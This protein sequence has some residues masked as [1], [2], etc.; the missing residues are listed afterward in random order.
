MDDTYEELNFMLDGIHVNL[1]PSFVA[2]TTVFMVAARSEYIIWVS[3]E[4]LARVNRGLKLIKISESLTSSHPQ[5]LTLSQKALLDVTLA[6]SAIHKFRFTT[7]T[8]SCFFLYF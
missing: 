2:M 7:S 1:L 4:D 6:S 5:S 3:H 8:P